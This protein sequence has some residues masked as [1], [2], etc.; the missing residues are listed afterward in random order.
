LK[1]LELTHQQ[2]TEEFESRYGKGRYH[3]SAVYRE[4]FQNGNQNL[5]GVK[6]LQE[7]PDLS[8]RLKNDLSVNRLPVVKIKQEGGLVKFTSRLKDG[9]K[10]ET[11]IIPMANHRTVCVSSQVGCRMGCAFC[12]T[13]QMGFRRNLDVEEIVAQVYAAKFML[14]ADVKNLVFMGMGEPFDNFDNVIQSVRVL[15]DQRGFNIARRH[16][17]LSTVGD[18]EGIRKLAKLGWRDIKLAISLNAPNDDIRSKI[19]PINKRI[20]MGRLK[21]AL[22]DYPL[23]KTGAFFIEYV[24]IKGINDSREHAR[25]LVRF[26]RPLKIK[27]NLIPYNPRKDFSFKPPSEKDTQRFLAHLLEDGVFVRRRTTRGQD[28]Q[29]ACGQLAAG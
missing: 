26:L 21:A 15:S 19:M 24:L 10:T 29:G 12:E 4:I 8:R 5:S 23:G 20:P 2:L 18:D 27:I 7:S 22:L 25:E 1:L 3:A 13:G 16:M 17:T 9:L 28:I 6:A 11:V 14:A